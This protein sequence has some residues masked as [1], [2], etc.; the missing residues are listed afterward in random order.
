MSESKFRLDEQTAVVTGSSRG[1]GEAIARELAEAGAAVVLSA[2]EDERERLERLRDELIDADHDGTATYAICD[3]TD[4]NAVEALADET[5]TEF[6]SV[7]VLVNNAGGGIPTPIKDLSAERWEKV[8][9]LNLTGT[10]NC[11]NI[12]G[13]HICDGGGSIVNLASRAGIDGFPGMSPYGAAKAAIINLTKT[14]A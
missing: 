11:I 10:F 5:I 1:I 2:P 9:S 3:V 8:V 14:V 13:Q 7:D 6:G 12:V 4:R